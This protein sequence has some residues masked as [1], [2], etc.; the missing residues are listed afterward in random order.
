[1]HHQSGRHTAPRRRADHVLERHLLPGGAVGTTPTGGLEPRDRATDVGADGYGPT[2]TVPCTCTATRSPAV[3]PRP[4]A[5]QSHAE[6]EPS[7][8]TTCP[9]V[10]FVQTTVLGMRPTTST[11]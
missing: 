5:S 2:S 3:T 10:T 1:M 6:A 8:V 7:S 4:A 9:V 11:S